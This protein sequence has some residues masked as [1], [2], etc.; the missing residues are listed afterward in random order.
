MAKSAPKMKM[1]GGGGSGNAAAPKMRGG[2]GG[3]SGP[4]MY[5]GA[6]QCPPGSFCASSSTIFFAL[7]AIIVILLGIVL[8]R[9][10]DLL[11]PSPVRYRSYEPAAH[12]SRP[13]LG[14]RPVAAG[15]PSIIIQ[16]AGVGGAGGD[17]RYQQAPQPL[18]SWYGGPE[19]PP[20]GGIAPIPINIPTQGLP[21]RFQSVGIMTL[22]DGQVLPLYG[23]RTA[24][25]TDR[26]N[27][28]TRTDTFNPVPIPVS[29]K[30]RDCMEDTGCEELMDGES[31]TTFGTNN[32]GKV[33]I[34]RNDGPKYIP[35]I[36]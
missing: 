23:R 19:F 1:R 11:G 10:T 29:Y 5:G 28:Y 14:P 7:A 18:K 27:Y 3:S 4:T 6:D 20:R 22:P 33:H 36:I 2:G 31:I 32:N 16:A 15:P 12:A 21:E 34:Y 25:S 24:T 35:G 26:W 8:L 9:G 30:R 13:L 17:D